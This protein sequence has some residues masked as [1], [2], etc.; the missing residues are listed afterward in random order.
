MLPVIAPAS[1]KSFTRQ[2]VIVGKKINKPVKT[3]G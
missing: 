3:L 1:A 2:G